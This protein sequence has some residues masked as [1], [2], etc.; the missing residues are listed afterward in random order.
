MVA[1]GELFL[2][3]AQTVHERPIYR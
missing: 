2:N 3:E 1:T